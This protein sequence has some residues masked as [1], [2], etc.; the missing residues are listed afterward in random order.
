MEIR[1]VRFLVA[2]LASLVFVAGC[3]AEPVEEGTD[4]T[5]DALAG[6]CSGTGRL[7]NCDPP[8]QVWCKDRRGTQAPM[9]TRCEVLC[10][11]DDAIVS[12]AKRP[13]QG[14]TWIGVTCTCLST[15]RTRTTRCFDES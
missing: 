10:S 12:Y 3:A 11:G 1:F 13:S 14:E 6:A 9:Q 7:S 2:G 5:Q 4:E 15:N 8:E